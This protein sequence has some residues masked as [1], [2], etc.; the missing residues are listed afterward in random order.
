MR[1][2]RA[3]VHL[4]DDSQTQRLV[5]EFFAHRGYRVTPAQNPLEFLARLPH[6]KE[7]VMLMNLA[8]PEIE[9]LEVLRRV[10]A[11]DG[12]IQV[13]VL[14][15]MVPMSTVVE[16]LRSGAEACFFKPLIEMNPLLQ[17]VTCSFRKIERWWQTLD[18]FSCRRQV[19]PADLSQ[20]LAGLSYDSQFGQG[21]LIP[22]PTA[23]PGV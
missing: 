12:G 22:L 3:L 6:W 23:A 17:A 8:L 4:D 15:E 16:S 1:N 2:E 9:G 19:A 5:A 14:T 7:R 13:I 18:E 10:K 21:E 11:F 20:A